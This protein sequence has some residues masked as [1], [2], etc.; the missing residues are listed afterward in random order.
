MS[1]EKGIRGKTWGVLIVGLICLVALTQG[2]Q[3]A[4]KESGARVSVVTAAGSPP[5]IGELIG[6]RA[7]AIVVQTEEGQAVTFALKDIS[8][9]SVQRK[10]KVALGILLGSL[11]G[12][13]VGTLL[14]GGSRD[15]YM[16]EATI[17]I[18]SL[19]MVAGGFAG[20]AVGA[21]PGSKT[22]VLTKMSE[23]EIDSLLVILRD[24][25]R[26]RGYQ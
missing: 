20:W 22:Y 14:S 3:A 13:T 12:A 7:D 26:V 4:A 9:I 1:D 17:L 21:S 18:P 24:K 19:V 10:K 5:V 15:E 16:T 2:L 8:T 23:A 11:T 6:A 25:A